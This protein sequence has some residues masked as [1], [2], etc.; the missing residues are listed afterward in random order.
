MLLTQQESW[1]CSLAVRKWNMNLHDLQ[2]W[3]RICSVGQRTWNAAYVHHVYTWVFLKHS[4]E[5]MVCSN[6]RLSI[7]HTGYLFYYLPLKHFENS[8][9]IRLFLHHGCFQSWKSDEYT[10]LDFVLCSS[11]SNKGTIFGQ[12]LL[13]IG[14]NVTIFSLSDLLVYM[15]TWCFVCS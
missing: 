2:W 11:V 8:M 1:I 6:S 13:S 15:E 4:I 14:E 5:T 3:K 10:N 7:W 12:N 9:F